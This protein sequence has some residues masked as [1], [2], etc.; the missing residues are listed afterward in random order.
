MKEKNARSCNS[1]TFSLTRD[2]G[3]DID[4]SKLVKNFEKSKVIG[5]YFTFC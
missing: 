3:L 4:K 5:D 1:L 2:T